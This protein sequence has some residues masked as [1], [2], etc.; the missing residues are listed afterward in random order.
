MSILKNAPIK[1]ILF[2]FFI[3]AREDLAAL[4]LDYQ[5]VQESAG[6]DDEQ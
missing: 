2:S 1:V 5:E 6:S 4:E 3:S